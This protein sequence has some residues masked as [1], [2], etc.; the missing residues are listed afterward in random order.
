MFSQDS[1][2]QFDFGI[3]GKHLIFSQ[4]VPVSI[5]TTLPEGKMVDVF[6]EHAGDITANKVGLTANPHA[7]C[8]SDGTVSKQ[9]Q[10]FVTFVQ[11]GTLTFYTCGAS[12]FT[13]NPAGGL[14]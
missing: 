3:T 8:R 10:L 6:V 7:V 9:D 4:P 1:S 12:M 2:I 14:A 11:S 5:Q 13:M